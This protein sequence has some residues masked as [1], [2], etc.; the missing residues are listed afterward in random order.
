MQKCFYTLMP[1]YEAEINK[2][3]FYW[4]LSLNIIFIKNALF[5]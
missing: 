1:C 5:E 3:Y 4:R 2:I